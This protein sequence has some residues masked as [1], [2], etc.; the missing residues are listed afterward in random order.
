[1][2]WLKCLW[3]IIL[4]ALNLSTLSCMWK[5][6]FTVTSSTLS[7]H[8]TVY[9][10]RNSRV[11]D[12]DS[13]FENLIPQVKRIKSFDTIKLRLVTMQILSGNLFMAVLMWLKFL[14]YLPCPYKFPIQN[15]LLACINF[16]F[17]NRFS[18]VLQHL[19]TL[20]WEN[21]SSGVSNQVRLKLA[22]SATEASMKFE[23]LVTET[24]DITL[25]RQ[26]TT[27]AL[28]RLRGCPVRSAPLLFAY[29]IRHLFSWPGSFYDKFRTKFW[30]ENNLP[31]H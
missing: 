12:S 24:R 4:W 3:E 13:I 28:I 9:L 25:T 19:W 7:M 31:F 2:R 16:L 27:K 17:L 26:R 5:N 14:D 21:I 22:C 15:Y 10:S 30:Q 29:D 8:L 6:H 23:F 1:M 11:C 18:E 20:L